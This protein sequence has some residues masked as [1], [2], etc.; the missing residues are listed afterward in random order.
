MNIDPVQ[1]PELFLPD[2]RSHVVYPVVGVMMALTATAVAARFYTRHCLVKSLGLDDWLSLLA[3]ACFCAL[4]SA[5]F[6]RKSEEET[7]FRRA[8]NPLPPGARP[9]S[10]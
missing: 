3:L 8:S 1:N 5:T 7:G 9:S 4:G 6:V 10:R 2:S